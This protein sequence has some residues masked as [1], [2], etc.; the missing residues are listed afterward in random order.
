[1]FI[2]RSQG[3]KIIIAFR[4]TDAVPSSRKGQKSEASPLTGCVGY[5][6]YNA[7]EVELLGRNNEA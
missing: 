7:I 4:G 6:E 5:W 2:E 1:M 3:N